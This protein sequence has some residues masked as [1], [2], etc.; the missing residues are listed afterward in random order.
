MKGYK[1][2]ID[3]GKTV[4]KFCM[5]CNETHENFMGISCEL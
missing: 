2:R 4:Y 5:R 3:C 1:I